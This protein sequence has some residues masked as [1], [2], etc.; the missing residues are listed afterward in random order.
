[1]DGSLGLSRPWATE[2]PL[3]EWLDRRHPVLARTASMLRFDKKAI[4]GKDII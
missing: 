4:R 2:R 3:G 1:M